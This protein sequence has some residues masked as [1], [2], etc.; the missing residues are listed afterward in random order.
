MSGP[1]FVCEAVVNADVFERIPRKQR[2]KDLGHLVPR[3]LELGPRKI[4]VEDFAVA[5]EYLGGDFVGDSLLAQRG[6][7]LGPRPRS[8]GE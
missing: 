3:H 2:R 5:V 6:S 1:L 7:Q 8:E 4:L